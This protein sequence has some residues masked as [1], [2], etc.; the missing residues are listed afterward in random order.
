MGLKINPDPT[1]KNNLMA[2]GWETG[3]GWYP[4]IEEMIEELKNIKD[5]DF[6]LIQV[7]EK[8]GLLRVYVDTGTDEVY[9]IIS[10]YETLSSHICE[11]CGKFDTSKMRV[12]HG[13]YM[14]RCDECWSKIK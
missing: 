7:K 14:T 13:W 8:F 9:D 11:E 1:L 3:K 4:L 6:E 10:R 2:F 5:C 12:H